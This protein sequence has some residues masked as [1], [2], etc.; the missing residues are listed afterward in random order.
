MATYY[1][2]TKTNLV[3]AW[4]QVD[5]P[6]WGAANNPSGTCFV[7]H[8]QTLVQDPQSHHSIVHINTGT[9]DHTDPGW[10]PWTYK[11]AGGG[12]P[13]DPT[14][15]DP[16]TGY[17]PG[18]SA[19][20]RPAL[21]C[22]GYGPPDF[23]SFGDPSSIATGSSG[24][25][26]TFA[27]AQEPFFE[28]VFADGVFA[29]LPM[30]GIVA[31]NS[32]AFNLT[33]FDTTMS[34]YLNLVFARPEDQRYPVRG[35]FDANSIFVH[36]VPPFE[37][38]E[39]CRTYTLPQGARLFELSSHMHQWGVL[40]RVWG[41]P[42][43]PC[44]PACPGGFASSVGCERSSDKPL[45]TGPGDPAELVY[46]TTDYTDPLQ[47][48]FEP[49]LAHD[50]GDVADRTYLFCAVYDN[51]TTPES[52]PVKLRSASPTPPLGLPVG[53]PCPAVLVACVDGSRKGTLCGGD[54]ARCPGSVC[55][56]CP[57]RG[58]M[59]TGDEMFILLGSYF[60]PDR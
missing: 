15:V 46:T 23:G 7:Y 21:A 26:P 1:D 14:A 48:Y 55:D 6:G 35:I 31:W 40:F 9:H 11:F 17:N 18:C 39:Y 24:N 42:Q 47:L 58:G 20:V 60:V 5:C 41:P 33:R 52:P 51:G 27:G 49:P 3:P 25:A 34:Q 19:A 57:V 28:Q 22:V 32:H 2:L 44:I 53:G 13:C 38:R 29:M 30:Q 10:G 8:R 37:T 12:A 50:S 59:T 56:A 4:A 54:D 43:T 45:C 16:A 36:D